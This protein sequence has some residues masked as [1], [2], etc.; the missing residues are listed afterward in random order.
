MEISSFQESIARTYLEKDSARGRL[1][2]YAWLVEEVGELARAMRKADAD[3][4]RE[5]I[6]DVFAW[7]A[8]LANLYGISLEDAVEK[9]AGGC[10]KCGETPCAC[11]EPPPR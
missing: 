1:G 11:E 3:S 10:P 5:E 9:Y 6:A 7:L 8:S 4:L 2:T